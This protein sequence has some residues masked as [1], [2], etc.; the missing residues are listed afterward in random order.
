MTLI[1]KNVGFGKA[2]HDGVTPPSNI[3]QLWYNENVGE[4]IHYYYNTNSSSWVPLIGSTSG[5]GVIK[6]KIAVRVVSTGQESAHTYNNGS[7]TITVNAAEGPIIIDGVELDLNDR[8]LWGGDGEGAVK[9]G[10]YIVS[11]VGDVSTPWVL[12][13]AGDSD[14]NLEFLSGEITPSTEGVLNGGIS[15]IL[16]TDASVSLGTS[17]LKY[18]PFSIFYKRENQTTVTVGGLPAGSIP[19]ATLQGV[20]DKILYPYLQPTF[21][22]FSISGQAAN[23]ELGQEI[24]GG[25]DPVT[26]LWSTTNNGNIETNSVDIIDVT[27]GNVTIGSNL[28]NDGSQAIAIG[29]ISNDAPGEIYQ[30]KIQAEDTE[31]NF[32]E[33][34]L[35]Y[36]WL[37]R[38]CFFL[39]VTDYISPSGNDATISTLVNGLTVNTQYE[40]SATRQMTKSFS[41]TAHYIYFVWDNS[42]GGDETIFIA[43]NFPTTSWVYKTFTYTNSFGIVRTFKIFRSL[44]ILSTNFNVEVL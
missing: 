37:P 33:R 14:S 34:L 35:T 10:I 5:S 38:R 22:A 2:I 29:E 12:T 43:N 36:T 30:F 42:L 18:T 39:S 25:S 16:T 3:K 24:N 28:A 6:E 26:F 8:I 11:E 7:K 31:E 41:P 9:N 19:P 13:R 15:W 27:D 23:L 1:T 44:N 32:F 21:S 4:F 40:L 20:L 17:L